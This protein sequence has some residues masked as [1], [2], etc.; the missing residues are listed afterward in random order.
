MTF[1]ERNSSSLALNDSRTSDIKTTAAA[2]ILESSE[3]VFGKDAFDE[4]FPKKFLGFLDGRNI[5]DYEGFFRFVKERVEKKKAENP[6]GMAYKL[7]FSPDICREYQDEC[8][9]TLEKKQEDEKRE[10]KKKEREM[11]CPACGMKFLP[12]YLIS[13]PRCAFEIQEFKSLE[14]IVKYKKYLRLPYEE[15][16]KYDLEVMNF[17]NERPLAE[18]FAY[19]NSEKGRKQKM[20]FLKALDKKYKLTG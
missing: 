2:E 1:A 14:S 19:F 3:K 8:E 5:P 16:K 12:D 9:R 10:R 4:N 17:M 15:R 7:I 6:R 20:E 18:R 13:C 11:T